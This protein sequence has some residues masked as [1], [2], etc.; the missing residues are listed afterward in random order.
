MGYVDNTSAM[1]SFIKGASNNERLERIVVLFGLCVFHLEAQVWLEWI[2]SGANWSDGLSREFERDPFIA[3]HQFLV[4]AI[5]PDAS[6][7][8]GPL[9]DVW[10]RA[11]DGVRGTA[12]E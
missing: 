6:W 12:L 2:D 9:E 8:A 3:M 7:W 11:R 5:A 10:A 4:D 1:A